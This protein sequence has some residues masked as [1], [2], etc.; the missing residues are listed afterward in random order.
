VWLE[1]LDSS[2][3][4]NLAPGRIAFSHGVN[5]IVGDNGQG[6]TNLLE[7]VTVLG[8][9]RSFRGARIRAW[10]RHGERALRVEGHV[11]SPTGA[12]RLRQ[13]VELD[14][15][16]QRGLSLDGVAARVPE[17]LAVC[18]V[19]AM[20]SGDRDLVVGPPQARRGYLDRLIFLLE[21]LTWEDLRGYQRTLRQRNAALYRR[22]ARVELDAW[23]SRLASAAAAVVRRRR[24]IVTR[25]QP[26]LTALLAALLPSE[27][28][29]VEIS[30]RAEP[31]LDPAQGHEVLVHEY[32]K[33]YTETSVRDREQGFTGDGPH[34]HDLRLRADGRAAR[35]AL[36]AGQAKSVALAFRL[37]ALELVEATRSERLPVV[38]DDVDAELDEAALERLLG[39]L[40]TERQILLSSAHTDMVRLVVPARRRLEM[41]AG[42]CSPDRDGAQG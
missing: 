36:S 29:R 30:Y 38:V 40:G 33:R 35:D 23:T 31:W 28:P 2:G 18:P 27:S 9:L 24:E 15:V 16:L 10:V 25:L 20:G 41:R 8:N 6:K 42:V 5:L 13:I 4:R 11:R 21:P 1:S 32:E 34:R 14:P 17:Y 7:A 37:A 22:A 3:Y 19:F 26:T 12:R 39:V